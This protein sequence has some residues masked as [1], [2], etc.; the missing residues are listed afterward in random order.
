MSE[1][2]STKKNS[3]LKDDYR[4]VIR[5]ENYYKYE[6]T[7]SELKKLIESGTIDKIMADKLKISRP[8]LYKYKSMLSA[9]DNK[10]YKSADELQYLEKK[11]IPVPKAEKPIISG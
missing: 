7:K 2:K 8:T 3:K 5:R 6:R 9:E 1:D 4:P 11:A 10:V